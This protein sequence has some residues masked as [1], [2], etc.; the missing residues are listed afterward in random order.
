[1]LVVGLPR[2]ESFWAGRPQAERALVAL[3]ALLSAG[4]WASS[5]AFLRDWGGFA[6]LESPGHFC[7]FLMPEGCRLWLKVSF[8]EQIIWLERVEP[9]TEEISDE[10]RRDRAAYPHSAGLRPRPAGA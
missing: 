10:P 4:E 1:M 7:L 2:L 3:H 5:D 9:A 6:S 8:A